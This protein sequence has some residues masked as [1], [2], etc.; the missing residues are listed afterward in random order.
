MIVRPSTHVRRITES[1]EPYTRSTRIRSTY[2]VRLP[3]GT[4]APVV[5]P[6]YL[7][8][9]GELES[10]LRVYL[11]DSTRLSTLGHSESVAYTAGVLRNLVS[12]AGRGSLRKYRSGLEGDV[13]QFLAAWIKS[14][15]MTELQRRARFEEAI[16]LTARLLELRADDNE[17]LGRA[18]AILFE[19]LRN[20]PITVAA[21]AEPSP[22]SRTSATVRITVERR[23]A[24]PHL[25]KTRLSEVFAELFEP[26]TPALAKNSPKGWRVRTLGSQFGELASRLGRL[27]LKLGRNLVDAARFFAGVSSNRIA[28]PITAARKARSYHLELRGP[29]QT[30]TI[31]QFLA[32]DDGLEVSTDLLAKAA[33]G[34][35]TELPVGQRHAHL[36]LR[37]ATEF[38]G[39]L[40]FIAVFAERTP[41]S[42]AVAAVTS[43]VATVIALLMALQAIEV[44][45]DP[46]YEPNDLFDVLLAFPF[47]VATASVLR[48]QTSIWGGVLASRISM[49]ITVLSCLAT[50]AVSTLPDRYLAVPV[51]VAW[52]V[53]VLV[54]VSN[55]L[56]AGVAV[57][58]RYVVH[59]SFVYRRPDDFAAAIGASQ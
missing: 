58:R 8:A 21:S 45:L 41:G 14:G 20:Y 30:F 49:L 4:D 1:I 40:R 55:S 50:L 36:Y 59:R 16:S 17:A 47:L 33:R 28:F 5:I 48:P 6:I 10:G 34:L 38:S 52:L 54:L 12:R 2:S 35:E 18:S 31:Q 7:S 57:L 23:S 9:R 3:A 11:G 25:A 46:S 26:T 19:L 37:D 13:L 27:F 53:I 42:M 32:T 39:G 29:E 56:A 22:K 44:S 15:T 24:V 51:S 43:A